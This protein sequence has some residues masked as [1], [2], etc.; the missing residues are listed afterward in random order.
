MFLSCRTLLWIA[1]GHTLIDSLCGHPN[2]GPAVRAAPAE[3]VTHVMVSDSLVNDRGCLN[4]RT[5][6]ET[7]S[8]DVNL[9]RRRSLNSSLNQRFGERVFYVL[10]QRPAQRS[11]PVAAI[12][13]RFLQ[14]P[15]T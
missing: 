6:R 8:A 2:L 4:H 7:F 9:Q 1:C 13:A 3:P 10:L 11:R 5:E 15:L 12:R 14:N